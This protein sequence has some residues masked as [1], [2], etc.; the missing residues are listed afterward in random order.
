MNLKRRSTVVVAP[1]EST[2]A[3]PD[4]D[5]VLEELEEL[6]DI[7]DSSA[8]LEQVSETIRTLNRARRPRLFG[9][10]RSRFGLQ[11]AG[12]AFVGSFVFG[13]PMIVEEGTLEVGAFLA[14]HPLYLG[15]TLLIG[16][17]LVRGILNSVDFTS[18]EADFL[19]GRIPLRLLGIVA[20]ATLTSLGLMTI[21]GRVDW[22][23]PAVAG[24]QCAVTGIVMAVG[25][26]LGDVLPEG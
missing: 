3:P 23:T 21:W 5:D 8:E 16:F 20:I 18:V 22:T 7:V 2:P 19:Y 1:A 9:R 11:D 15:V 12:E 25:A 13:L 17:G 24:G 14:R 6:E 4:Y 26:A 10:F